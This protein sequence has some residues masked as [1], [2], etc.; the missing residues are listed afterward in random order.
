MSHPAQDWPW[1][2]AKRSL[3]P[4]VHR[5]HDAMSIAC[6]IAWLLQISRGINGG[7]RSPIYLVSIDSP[8]PPDQPDDVSLQGDLGFM[9]RFGV[10]TGAVVTGPDFTAT[11]TF[12]STADRVFD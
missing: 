4:A 8:N 12:I 3:I 5:R 10:K 11:L 9:A 6:R 2:G 1:R 7:R